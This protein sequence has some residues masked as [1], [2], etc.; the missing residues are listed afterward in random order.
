MTPTPSGL[1]VSRVVDGVD[2][3]RVRALGGTAA[4]MNVYMRPDHEG[5]DSHP[6]R[7]IAEIVEDC[8][9][10][11]V[12]RRHR[13]PDLRPRG[14]G[15]GDLQGEGAGAGRPGRGHRPRSAAPR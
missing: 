5:V 15:P 14:R 8:A 2:A 7:L 6:A 9:R 12:L 11:D 3:R 1:R 10:E 13:D 4:K